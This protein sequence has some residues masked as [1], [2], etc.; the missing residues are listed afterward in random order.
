MYVCPDCRTPLEELHCAPC[1]HQYA[2]VD[3]LP[4]LLSNDERFQ[5]GKDIA[6]A[7]DDIYSE[8][9]NVWEN[10]GRTPQFIKSFS[11]LLSG[12][13]TGRILEIGCG[14]GYL[15]AAIAAE[16]KDA[17]DISAQAL[18][19][20]RTRAT[21]QFS[22]AL[23]ER[24]PFPSESFDLVTCVGVMEHFIDD[25]EATREIW[26]VLKPGAYYVALIHV[27]LNFLQRVAQKYSEYIFPRFRP[28][29]LL[30]WIF[31][32][33]Y[34]PITQPIQ[35]RYTM[36]SGRACLE[37]CAFTVSR[38]ISGAGFIRS[39]RGHHPARDRVG[40]AAPETEAEQSLLGPHV[41]VYVAKK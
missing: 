22:V 31:G 35:R 41:V 26:R 23:A 3:G 38:V 40:T 37:S 16:K 17:I 13:S 10:Q 8:H 20:A 15:V 6:G 4:I 9:T 1:A 18:L 27:D 19:R 28:A 39:E 36:Q 11:A 29:A 12:L 5:T 33:V 34:R 25:R 24:L 32:K 30:E 21:A 7:Y 14:E 2:T